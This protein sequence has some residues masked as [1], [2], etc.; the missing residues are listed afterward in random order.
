MGTWSKSKLIALTGAASLFLTAVVFAGPFKEKTGFV[1]NWFINSVKLMEVDTTGLKVDS[2]T[3][4]TGDPLFDGEPTLV[5]E[6]MTATTATGTPA[7]GKFHSAIVGRKPLLD[8]SRVPSGKFGIERIPTTQLILEDGEY[9]STGSVVYSS[10]DIHD[11]IRFIGSDWTVES[12]LLGEPLNTPVGGAVE[13]T[14]YGTG[15]NML[16]FSSAFARTWTV[17]VDGV[18]GTPIGTTTANSSILTSRSYPPNQIFPVVS[19]LVKGIH[20]VTITT[21][22]GDNRVYGFEILNESTTVA[23][24]AGS[25]IDRGK[26]YTTTATTDDLTTFAAHYQDG[27]STT[28]KTVGGHQVRY[29][30]TDGTIKKAINY[31]NS[32]QATFAS[33]DYSNSEIVQDID[34]RQF[35]V[36]RAD[37]FSTLTTSASDR[38]FTLDDGTTTLVGNQIRIDTTSANNPVIIDTNGAYLTVTFV[39][40][41]LSLVRRDNQ[42]AT[43]NDDYEVFVD[44]VT[45]GQLQDN[46]SQT[47]YINPIVSG[48]SFGTH[49]V[50]IIRNAAST[51][52]VGVERFLIYAPT[53]P[54]LTAGQVEID[55]TYKLTDLVANTTGDINY[56]S[57][58]TI[59]KH[60]TRETI[61][62]TNTVTLQFS[63]VNYIG[64]WQLNTGDA[65]A[66]IDQTFFGTGVDL[67]YG[68]NPG[69]GNSTEITLNGVLVS[70][71]NFTINATGTGPAITVTE[72]GTGTFT[73]STGILDHSG[74]VLQGSGLVISGLALDTYTVGYE[75]TTATQSVLSS[76]DVVT[77]TYNYKNN[78]LN[79]RDDI[80]GSNS[81][82]N[83]ILIPGATKNPI[84]ATK[85]ITVPGNVDH[86]Q[87]QSGIIPVSWQFDGGGGT[88][89]PKD[90]Y[91]SRNGNIVT[92]MIQSQVVTSG[93][94][95]TTLT[96]TV[97]LPEWAR[98]VGLAATPATLNVQIRDNGSP[99]NTSGQMDI[100]STGFLVVYRD[101]THSAWTNSASGGMQGVTIVSYPVTTGK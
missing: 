17:D 74:S 94:G 75:P 35:G 91:I 14:F 72:Y 87:D 58:G 55:S 39:G 25:I 12:G 53:K 22:V 93:T 82:K 7:A 54:E 16:G 70:E 59:R 11:R 40:T 79:I 61:Y 47:E 29:F 90:L 52:A 50:K 36:G 101:A 80:V 78:I 26:K 89:G 23:I 77:P 13:V 27:V 60:I 56:I 34:Y 88:G 97:P 99:Q 42:T 1:F 65:A 10:G 96:S 37:D 3:T 41:G 83:E 2:I 84:I 24:P 92:I 73:P 51:Y 81:I 30:D 28:A 85:G 69:H 44:G 95:S 5:A 86:S 98:P 64:G 48:L 68:N 43:A 15:L 19:G 21:T 8:L 100:L 63:A 9:S 76:Y 62:K 71:S 46:A 49:V 31:A 57:Q 20:T 4:L 38:A 66:E 45:I 6:Y 18:A 67:R 33:A 32:S